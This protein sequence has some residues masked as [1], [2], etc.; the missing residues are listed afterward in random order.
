MVRF[1]RERGGPRDQWPEAARARTSKRRDPS[2]QRLRK[3]LQSTLAIR[4]GGGEGVLVS[5]D[6]DE[7]QRL[8]PLRRVGKPGAA[9]TWLNPV[10]CS[11]QATSPDSR[12]PGGTA[13]LS[14]Q[15]R[16]R[17]VQ[18]WIVECRMGEARPLLVETDLGMGQVCQR[19]GHNEPQLLRDV[20]QAR[21]RDDAACLAAGRPPLNVE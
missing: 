3:R 10:L 13:P 12:P 17:T 6:S 14:D 9:E 20:L 8:P 16:G 19:I 21:P 2:H 15:T 18:E 4:G 1:P 7:P 11:Y 5:A